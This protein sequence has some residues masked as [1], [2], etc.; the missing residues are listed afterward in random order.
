MHLWRVAV[1]N[2]KLSGVSIPKGSSIAIG[3]ASAN[4][5]EKVFEDGEL[6]DI[7]R[8]KAGAHLAFGS[9]PHHCPG[10]PLARQEMFSA[11]TILLHRLDKIRVADPDEQF[12]HAPSSFL[13]GLARLDLKFE[14]READR[15]FPRASVY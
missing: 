15:Y 14:I 3:Y 4:R 7:D 11:F 12:L 2:T 10:A 9:G 13:R 1:E 5:D 8:Q 6:F